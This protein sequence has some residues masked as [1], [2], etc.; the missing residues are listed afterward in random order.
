MGYY[1][2]EHN[3]ENSDHFESSDGGDFESPEEFTDA[4]IE[5]AEAYLLEQ[6]SLKAKSRERAILKI[7][8]AIEDYQERK[9]LKDDFDYLSDESDKESQ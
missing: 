5:A 3:D 9:R 2:H 4:E 8:H 7:R 6:A 1:T